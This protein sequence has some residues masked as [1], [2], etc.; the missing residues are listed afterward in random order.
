MPDYRLATER[1]AKRHGIS[2][3]RFTRQIKQES[4]FNPKAGSSA[5]ARGI[6]QFMPAT[7]KAEGVNLDDGKAAD[8]LDGAARLMARYLKQYDG[9]WRSALT[10]YNA[11]PGRVGGKLPAETRH[12]ID[13]IVGSGPGKVPAELRMA[14]LSKPRAS[15]GGFDA[16]GYEAARKKAIVGGFLAK[17]NPNS[18]LLKT[19]ALMTEAPTREQFTTSNPQSAAGRRA[20]PPAA[21]AGGLGGDLNTAVHA[22][23]R[24][25]RLPITARQ[26][27]GHATGGDH[28]PAVKG[29]TAR[30]FGGDEATRKA[31]FLRITRKLGVKGA[32]YKGADIN[33]TKDGV[34]YQIISRDHGTGPHLHAGLRKAA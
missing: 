29:A 21:P 25:A 11:G 16:E 8:D 26:E 30:D 9:D 28:D 6:A 12:Y 33:V 19:G 1:A 14:R 24:L 5:G 20:T 18:L 32:V 17:R 23:E 31:A 10:A 13:V 4:G 2:P 22:L 7:A 3:T 27:P 15:G 34:R